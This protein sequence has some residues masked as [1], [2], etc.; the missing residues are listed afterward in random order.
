[1]A[2]NSAVVSTKVGEDIAARISKL[3]LEKG[4]TI[5][6][7]LRWG[8]EMVLQKWAGSELETEQA[9]R[10]SKKRIR[11]MTEGKPREMYDGAMFIDRIRQLVN[12][13]KK[14]LGDWH[15]LENEDYDHLISLVEENIKVAREYQEGLWMEKWLNRLIG[16]LRAEKDKLDA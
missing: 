4:V 6:E 11:L 13:E 16:E 9:T 10:M 15:P 12:K 7:V 14:V 1:M 5:S 8:I 2:G 3:A